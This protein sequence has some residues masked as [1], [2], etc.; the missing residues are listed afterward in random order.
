M[1]GPSTSSRHQ[2]ELVGGLAAGDELTVA[3]D[4]QAAR[5]RDRLVAH[6]V[7]LGELGVV[8]VADDLQQVQARDQADGRK[9][10]ERGTDDR[11]LIEEALLP[12]V[13]LDAHGRHDSSLQSPW[14]GNSA[15]QTRRPAP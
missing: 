7:T 8:V 6:A 15:A 11:A 4:D 9:S 2:L 10:H 3:V 5:G 14:T 12:P 13:I 1:R